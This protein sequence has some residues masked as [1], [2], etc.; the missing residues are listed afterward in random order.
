[1]TV[2]G[3]D[4][5]NVFRTLPLSEDDKKNLDIVKQRFKEHFHP[6]VN[7]TYERY[8]FNQMKQKEGETFNEFLTAA[9]LQAKKCKFGEL[10]DELL[11]DRIIVG[12]T[13]D[14]VRE[15]LLSDPTVDLQKAVNLCKA[16][17]QAS[18]Q[19]KEIV[20]K[21]TRTVDA[22]TKKTKQL[23][24]KKT[25]AE[26]KEQAPANSGMARKACSF[27]GGFHRPKECP[28]Y[29][30]TCNKCQKKG[31]FA[32]VCRSSRSM[33]QHKVHAI[34][35][36]EDPEEEMYVSEL[37]TKT[38]KT[39]W[40]EE[41]QFKCGTKVV[42]KLDA[43][44]QCNVLPNKNVQAMRLQVFPSPV[45]R[46]ATYSNHKMQV[47]GEVREACTVRD[48]PAK[49]KFL[50]V[51][52]DVTPVLGQNACEL[53][54]LVK[55]VHTVQ[56]TQEDDEIFQGIGC[57]KNFVYD[58]DVKEEASKKLENKPPRRVPYALMDEV[59]QELTSMEQ[60]GIVEKIT[61][62]T[63]FCSEMVVVKQRG[64]IRICIDPVELNKVLIRRNYPLKTL[65]EIVAHVRGSKRFTLLDLKKGFWQMQ[66]SERTKKYLAFS[67]PWGRYCFKRVPF[68]IAT[69][70]E[71]FQQVISRILEG[72]PNAVNSMDDILVYAETSEQLQETTKKVMDALKEAG[73]KLNKDKCVFD[74]P[75]VKFLGHEITAEGLKIDQEKVAAI[76][77]LNEP[78]NKTELQRLLGM[79]QYLQKFVPNLADKTAPLRK[80]ITKD[81]EYLW[82]EEQSKA[83][84]EIKQALK[85]APTLA[86]YNVNGAMT[87]SVDASSKALGAVL[88]QE[89]KPVAYA[90]A[91][92]TEAQQNYPQIEKEAL[93]IR[94]GCR[95]FHQYI[96]G[97]PLTIET[98]HKPIE[99]IAKKPLSKAPPRLQRLLFDVQQYAPTIVYKKGTELVIADLLSR[100]CI[101]NES[102]GAYTNDIQVMAIVPMS[103]GTMEEL[104]RDIAQDKEIQEVI[105]ATKEGWPSTTRG[106][107]DPMKL[108]W[109]FRDE[110]AV[111]EDMLF[112]SDRIVVPKTWR[113]R[114]LV[115]IHAGHLGINSCLK[116]ARET[117]YWPG[118]T[119]DI[120]C[121]VERCATCQAT[122]KKPAREPLHL[123]EIPDL[124]W[125]R[126]ASDLFNFEGKS[127]VVIV[128][129]Y[130]GYLDFKKLSGES[131]KEVVNVM[132][133][134]LATHGVPKVIETDNGPCYAAQEFKNFSRDWGFQHL[135]SSP[136]YAQS[137]GLAERAVQTAKGILR[138]C[139]L[140][141][142][143]IQMAL[144]S[145]RNTPRS[146]ELGSPAQRLYSRRTRT[147]V[148]THKQL[149]K[150]EITQSV[151]DKLRHERNQQKAYADQHSKRAPA[152]AP[153]D[154][155]KVWEENRR[156]VP[157]TVVHL[158]EEPR[159]VIVQTPKGQYRR[160]TSFVRPTK[161]ELHHAA[162]THTTS[163]EPH[164]PQPVTDSRVCPSPQ[165]ENPA[166]STTVTK[167][168]RII[169]PVVRLDL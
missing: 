138:K 24:R 15:R 9:R 128:D 53:L 123:K 76:D 118:L 14:D 56:A 3:P 6:K 168:G 54:N 78:K 165:R 26:T 140:D 28:A 82:T 83:L 74:K 31:H 43:G 48:E 103:P 162:K 152:M 144:L 60:K 59:K 151:P 129:S 25:V 69:A 40:Q 95:K 96:Y 146:E 92:M 97:R 98:D 158:S 51:N 81:T 125:E 32:A 130:S 4:A 55:R 166:D 52:S 34:D 127:Y 116:R 131:S 58:A 10:T 108:Y 66:V 132:K 136:R 49:L 29:G 41:I 126:V 46:I 8:R 100:D 50:V 122:D 93:A 163:I 35:N 148:P 154:K 91:A 39:V 37:R 147:P 135:T 102:A 62:P 20:N 109:S 161:A 113:N 101:K 88:L 137:N 19:L 156:W 7:P 57:I 89:G 94:Y 153:G 159:S 79:I 77:Q 104:K 21:E 5:Q 47:I 67:T 112:R 84:A 99:S 164:A 134:W 30:K 149:L 17:E 124:P 61:E 23:P 68:G 80:L 107:S 36:H 2:I 105:Q 111:Y 110:L 65:E 167:S 18:Q 114:L 75:A 121:Y 155:V 33:V 70:P 11:R 64:K 106:L 1:M 143:D 85:S 38:S 133:E 27:C 42:M 157:G 160:N 90:S 86:Y 22:V 16:S 142:S 119:T 72:I 120:K 145:F 73:T 45:K 150:P 117:V 13:N 12:I 63:P 71:V 87:L 139:S 169:K 115:Q 141:G 44:A